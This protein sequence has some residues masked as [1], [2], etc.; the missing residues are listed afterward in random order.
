MRPGVEHRCRVLIAACSPP[1]PSTHPPTDRPPAQSSARGKILLL[2]DLVTFLWNGVLA[3]R[4]VCLLLD[5]PPGAPPPPR[6]TLAQPGGQGAP[7]EQG[8][9]PGAKEVRWADNIWPR[10]TRL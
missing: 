10:E 9:D 3:L 1:H 4:G 6:I 5:K 7:A 2:W 8:G